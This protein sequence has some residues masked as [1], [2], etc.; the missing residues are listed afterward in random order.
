MEIEYQIKLTD[1]TKIFIKYFDK[2]VNQ[3]KNNKLIFILI[4]DCNKVQ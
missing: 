4:N 3:L 1:I 2:G